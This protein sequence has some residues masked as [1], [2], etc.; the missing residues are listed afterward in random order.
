MF[1][2]YI[3]IALRNKRKYA[4]TQGTDPNVSLCYQATIIGHLAKVTD[5]DA[6]LF[7]FYVH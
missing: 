5:S 7:F 2:H 1:R 4:V 6:T 3:T